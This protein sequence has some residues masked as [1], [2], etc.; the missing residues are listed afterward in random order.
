MIV[1][2]LQKKYERISFEIEERFSDVDVPQ[3]IQHYYLLSSLIVSRSFERFFKNYG[4]V[5]I[6]D[7]T[8]GIGKEEYLGLGS[9]DDFEIETIVLWNR[10]C[11]SNQQNKSRLTY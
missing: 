1:D 10:F 3:P 5:F 9:M 8:A 4:E 2:E 11:K 6:D 7:F